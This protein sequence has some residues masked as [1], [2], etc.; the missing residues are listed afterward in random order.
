MMDKDA[1]RGLLDE[2]VARTDAVVRSMLTHPDREGE[3]GAAL[4][5]LK[6]LQGRFCSEF[7]LLSDAVEFWET[8]WRR[9]DLVRDQWLRVE[10]AAGRVGGWLLGRLQRFLDEQRRNLYLW[11][12]GFVC[13]HAPVVPSAAHFELG[14]GGDC[15][16]LQAHHER[17]EGLYE[18][19]KRIGRLPQVVEG[20]ALPRGRLNFAVIY[21]GG[22]NVSTFSVL[23]EA[24]NHGGLNALV[25]FDHPGAGLFG[26]VGGR[27]VRLAPAGLVRVGGDESYVLA[28]FRRA[29]LIHFAC[30]HAW[31]GRPAHEL[32][33]PVL[34]SVLTLE[35]VN[36]KLNTTCAL[37]WYAERSGKE[38][39]LIPEESVPVASV[40]VDLEGLC[41]LAEGAIARLEGRG[42]QRVVVKPS[43]GEQERG[44][45][46]F[47]L[48]VSRAPAVEHVVRLALESPVVIQQWVEPLGG[49]DFTWRVLVA[50]DGTGSPVS[51]GRFARL[52]HG[53]D[54]EMVR[55]TEMLRR[56]GVE[57][58]EAC[59]FLKRLD[60]VSVDAFRAV[61][62]YARE[63]HPDFPWAPLGGGSYAV[64]YFLG[65]DLIGD[66][67]IMEVNGNEV[68]G[69]WTHDRLYPELRGQSNRTVLTS[70]EAAARA[71]RRAL[72]G[73]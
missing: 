27:P 2:V 40:P 63:L 13:D 72:E 39:P 41:R 16:H 44:M 26:C 10:R 43:T 37:R 42:I 73:G 54:M 18:S 3:Y 23:R 36:D 1:H 69:M 68:A 45:G 22:W 64:P 59:R 67:F 17:L 61:S 50:L 20:F 51:V 60:A 31:T 49:C 9:T 33:L 19:V 7:P 53:D 62:G 65:V 66:A 56:V 5:G 35:V 6:D 38:L 15:P 14:I 8:L 57:G 70:A 4:E 34:R 30:P 21:G 12:R 55:D 58:A 32:G 29:A 24:A 46:R 25:A 47:D 71:Y 48:K 28:G 52:G 11:A